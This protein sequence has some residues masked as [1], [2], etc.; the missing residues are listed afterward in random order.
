[1]LV[2]FSILA[3]PRNKVFGRAHADDPKAVLWPLSI[4]YPLDGSIF[5]PGI[6]PPTFIW[7]DASAN[8]WQ[9]EFVFAD[10]SAP[11]QVETSGQR[12]QIGPIDPDCVSS[13]NELPQLTPKQ[14]ASRTWSPDVAT[15]AKIQ[16]RSATQPVILTITGYN[17]AHQATSQS[18]IALSTSLDPVG[19]PIF[20][21]DVPLMP[22]QGANGTVQPL[23]PTS[24]H[25]IK[26]RL[27][28]VRQ[29]ESHTVLKDM[30]TCANCHSFSGDGKTMGID[31]DGPANDKGLYA[32]VPVERHIS[33][34]NKDV[35][36]WNTDGQ[37]GKVRVGFMSQV[38]PDG[39]YVVS[40]F[41]GSALD[42][43]NTYYVT[44]FKDY[45]FLQVF[46]PTRGILEWYDRASATRQPLPGADNPRY[47]QTDG[48]W[49]PDGK[50]IVFARAEAKDPY[51][52]GQPK[53]IHA[54]DPNE[55]QIQYDL[56]RVPFNDGR[57]GVAEPISGASHNGMSN[58]FPK[59][60]PDGRWIVFVQC[61]N[62]QL[63]RP[64]SQLY[65]VPFG[66]GEARRLAANTS[67]MNSWH[68]FSPNGR[69]LVFS[70]KARSFYTQMYLTHIDEQG[71][72][73]PAILIEN[74]TAANRA[75]NLPE[76]VNTSGDGI[77]EIQVP[78]VN[79]YKMI[80]EARQLEEKGKA[81]QAL[82][83]WKKALALDPSNGRVQSGLGASL[84]FHSNVE[85]SFQHLR[86]AIRINPLSAQ[87]H[88][89]LGKFM[90]EQTHAEQAL[91]ELE[92]AITIRPHFE[93]CEEAL[94]KTFEAL[95]KD[96][97]ALSHWRKARLIDPT[98]VSATIGTAWLLATSPD[99]SLRDG[100]EAV[101]LA[102]SAVNLQPDNAE[103][104]DTLAVSCAEERL[105]S[106]ASSIETHA[107]ELAEAQANN[108]LTAAIRVHEALFAKQKP[109][110][111]GRESVV[112]DQTRWS[113]R[114]M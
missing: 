38:S 9:I 45:R 59:V 102:E 30:P 103:V 18:R 69:W 92:A 35:V 51:P 100:A 99:A 108:S 101:R 75:V 52:E 111:E 81:D 89:L 47:V 94:G 46:Y 29:S 77:E 40:T 37:A 16:Q 23:S 90:L 48:V 114:S 32:V 10:N 80:D 15:W 67:L 78:A 88:F 72:S 56:Y 1:M 76:F 17:S 104:L 21:R 33:I 39:R 55:T 93:L 36:Q 65:I 68:S 97:E 62:G 71:N 112:A 27:R 20:Y 14:A 53:A 84:Y 44:N 54:N 107:L 91:P 31:V 110:H 11:V 4:D 95:G 13:T 82:E 12:M 60:S 58:N 34:Q 96:S 42:I 109:F 22:S 28:D 7:R 79:Q 86:E 83:T 66:G 61:Q 50:Y 49:S 2:V 87:D 3:P 74:A 64:D 6:T 98:S 113:P 70:S 25:L 73:S 63:M 85:E 5:P 24:I 8:S 106:R 57:G 19:A 105:F 41:A 43:S 26:W